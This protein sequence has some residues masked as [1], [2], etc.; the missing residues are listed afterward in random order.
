MVEQDQLGVPSP[1]KA[2]HTRPDQAVT[3]QNSSL[4][5]AMLPD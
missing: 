3:E 4:S 1:V 2:N 5:G